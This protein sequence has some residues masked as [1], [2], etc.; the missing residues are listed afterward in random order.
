MP[1]PMRWMACLGAFACL[2]GVS[3]SAM[4]WDYTPAVI[5]GLTS[6][7][8]YL[9]NQETTLAQGA[10]KFP[11]LKG[12]IQQA[13]SEFDKQFPDALE[14]VTRLFQDI[15]LPAT[16]RARLASKVMEID[17][18][19]ALAALASEQAMLAFVRHVRESARGDMEKAT[20]Q[21][22]LAAVYEER[23]AAELSSPM[24]QVWRT[25]GVK[26]GVSV[27]M[28]LRM[29]LSWDRDPAREK[30]QPERS[31]FAFNSQ[32]GN[33]LSTIDL[34]LYP[35]GAEPASRPKAPEA[36]EGTARA[37]ELRQLLGSGTRVTGQGVARVADRRSTWVAFTVPAD[38]GRTVQQGRAWWVPIPGSRQSVL[39]LCRTAALPAAAA[40]AERN[41]LEPLWTA[42]AAS[43]VE[44]AVPR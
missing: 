21:L 25:R 34:L 18:E 14:V 2:I 17:R 3:G 26:P 6:I 35:Q 36:A 11:A 1:H 44:P 9:S 32:G 37:E 27:D 33:G 28:T 22:L 24:A 16:D 31:I 19:T 30:L 20:L 13:R 4:A 40:E 5:S 39:L 43:I 41:R 10:A 29:P 38:A 15:P 8:G 12:Q 7:Y 23:P 42:V